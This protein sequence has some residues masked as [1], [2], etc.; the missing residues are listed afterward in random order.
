MNRRTLLILLACTVVGTAVS[1]LTRRAETAEGKVYHS[2]QELALSP[3]GSTVYVTDLT[4][5]RVVGLDAQT[6]K[7]TGSSRIAAPYGLAASSD[8]KAL[9]VSSSR[10]DTVVKLETGELKAVGAVDVGRQPTGLALSADGATLYCCNQFSNTVSVID[11]ANMAKNRDIDVVREPRSCAPTPDGARLLVANQL[12]LG[13]NMN[14]DLGAQLSIVDLASGQRTD[15]LLA[16]GATDVGQVCCS[17]DGKWAYVV[18]LLARWLVPPTQLDRGWI[19]TNALTV[20]DIAG[21]RRLATVLLDDLDRGAANAYGVSLSAD[22]ATLYATHSGTHEVQIIDTAKLH[23]LIAER[24]ADDP[25]ALE[26][27]LTAVYRAGVRKRVPCGGVG[28]RG[29][30]AVADGAL[31][32]NYFSGDITK[33]GLE[34]GKVAATWSIGEQPAMDDVRTGEMLFHDARVCFQGWQ[35]CA[36]CH[37]DARTDGLAWDLLNDGIGNPKNAKSLL[38]SGATPPVMSLGVRDSMTTAVGT[39]F[40]FIQFHQPEPDEIRAV[41]AYIDSLKPARSP[42]VSKSGELSAAA[43]RGKEIFYSEQA[44]CSDCHPEPLY[45]DLQTYDVGTTGKYDRDQTNFDT[46]TLVEMFRSAPYLH[47]GSAVTMR[48]ALRDHNLED[49]HGHVSHLTGQQL[50]DLCEYVL[51]L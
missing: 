17:P 9:Y 37:P 2:P 18:H 50:D 43:K 30:V 26:D 4:A 33:I 8:G 25:V 29:V 28:P 3:T 38:L 36:T 35:S 44:G 48:E 49:R 23:K 6:G 27:D 41:S 21:G 51:S 39:G 45:T 34:R 13:S 5:D 10:E 40:R 24:P 16:R 22:G 1:L 11:T 12:P 14:D 42:F 31:V 32:A 47:D 20:V 7:S 15:V 46:P 19:A